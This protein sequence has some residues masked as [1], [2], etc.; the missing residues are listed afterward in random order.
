M[1][2]SAAF[3]AKMVWT[4]IF[5]ACECLA[6]A[7]PLTFGSILHVLAVAFAFLKFTKFL[8][9]VVGSITLFISLHIVV[10]LRQGNR[11]NRTLVMISQCK[12][13]MLF[14]LG[15]DHKQDLSIFDNSWHGIGIARSYV[16][17]A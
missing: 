6:F 13:I 2:R 10:N 4:T 14:L 3:S 15:G 9:M 7:F 16:K 1:F 11:T 12:L 8:V 17:E 5:M